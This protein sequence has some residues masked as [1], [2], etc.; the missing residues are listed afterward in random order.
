MVIVILKLK[1]EFDFERIVTKPP[2]VT[3]ENPG[4]HIND[5]DK[6]GNSN[7]NF[8]ITMTIFGDY[9]DHMETKK[10]SIRIFYFFPKFEL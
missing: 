9:L 7:S 4:L 10:Q 5:N 6:I 1:F 2:P 3:P 8:R